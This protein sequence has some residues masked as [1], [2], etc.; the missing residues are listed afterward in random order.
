MSIQF[1]CGRPGSGKS[2]GV[3]ENV[4]LP[5]LKLQRYVY[6]NIPLNVDV[7]YTDFPESK[8]LVVNFRND[9]LNG[10]Y[11]MSIP[12]GAVVII[13]ECWRFWPGGM[14]ANE[15]PQLDKEF[16]A[17]HR[18]KVGEGGLTQEIVLL[19][20]TPAQIAKVIRDLIDST[21]LTIKNNA[22]G[23]EKSYSL[24]IFSGCIPSIDRPGEPNVTGI[25]KYKPEIYK[26]Y[27]SH[28]KTET[29]LPG[30]EIRA[31]NRGTIWNHWYIRYV[32][33]LVFLSA[34]WGAYYTYQFFTGKKIPQ[35][36][37]STSNVIST[38]HQQI[39]KPSLV[40]PPAEVQSGPIESVRYR[41][42]AVM[43]IPN[44]RLIYLDDFKTGKL[45]RINPIYC[46]NTINGYECTRNGELI[47]QY[48]G[49]RPPKESEKQK[50]HLTDIVP[51][52]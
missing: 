38:K 42:S 48:T 37:Q 10:E 43:D 51:E 34:I 35:V 16:F 11:L 17:E 33:P 44:R 46:K 52:V 14:K 9:E 41:V 18:H 15:M 7:I 2:Y 1:Y 28:T 40:Q 13:D 31:D 6:T 4:I 39:V 26:Y 12:G 47:T 50:Q 29:G 30:I 21:A 22:V 8:G 19:T 23:S 49:Q 36:T 25:G 32:A 3:L 20:Q 27:K 45:I 5:A 24:R